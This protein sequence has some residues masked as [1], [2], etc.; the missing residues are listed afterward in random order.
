MFSPDGSRMASGSDD[1]TVRVWDVQTGQCQHKLEGHSAG[2]SS[3]VFSPNGSRVA[4]GSYDKTIRVWDVQTDQ[5]EHTLKGHSSWVSSVVFSPDGSRVASGSDDWTVRVWDVAR[6]AELLCYDSGTNH[7]IIN[8]SDD[9]TRIAVNGSLLSIPSQTPLPSTIA[10]SLRPHSN[11]RVSA[12]GINDDWVIMSF[13]RILWLP[14][15]YRPGR[16]ASYGNVIVIGSG[17]G[18]MTFVHC[19]GTRSSS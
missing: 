19:V 16:W 7:Q 13:V 17:I 9:S 14:P 3:V 2:I 15:E 10:G 12:L 8:F 11:V 1:E 4:S 5:C 18:R 6:S